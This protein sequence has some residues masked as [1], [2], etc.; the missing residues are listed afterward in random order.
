M[1]KVLSIEH[2][3]RCRRLDRNGSGRKACLFIA[4]KEEHTMLKRA[5]NKL[6]HR[7]LSKAMMSG[8]AAA[9]FGASLACFALTS[10]AFAQDGAK[11]TIPDLASS[12]FAWLVAPVIDHDGNF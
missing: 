11:A 3:R 10:P 4:G 1:A 6:H 2:W 8:T 7:T 9:V 5:S 12:E